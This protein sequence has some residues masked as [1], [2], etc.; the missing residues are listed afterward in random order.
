MDLKSSIRTI[1]DFPKKGIMFRDITTLLQD[2]EAYAQMMER[3]VEEA[4]KLGDFDLIAGA[5][6]RG[7]LF[8]APMALEMRKGMVLIRK[9]GKLPAAVYEVEYG[10][11]YGTSKLQIH[12]D[13]IKPGQRVL[14]V[15]DLLATGGTALA[16]AKLVEMC[17]GEIVGFIFPVE[18]P[19]LKGRELLKDY[20]VQ[21]VITFEGE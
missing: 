5:D 18:L 20:P 6:A 8:I 2:P 1:P 12:Q 14:L 17:G 13:A 21:S 9:P 10:L 3:L 7:Y 11:E 16:M 15:D 4:G 19:E